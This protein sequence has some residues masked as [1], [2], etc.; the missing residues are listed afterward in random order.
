M[1]TE[2]WVTTPQW[3]SP[4]TSPGCPAGGQVP[5]ALVD[6]S[7]GVLEEQAQ[8]APLSVPALCALIHPPEDV[9]DAACDVGGEAVGDNVARDADAP[10]SAPESRDDDEGGLAGVI[11]VNLLLGW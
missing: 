4:S 6:R 9:A 8:A 3:P 1:I 7:L 2:Y 10:K 11:I 5:Q